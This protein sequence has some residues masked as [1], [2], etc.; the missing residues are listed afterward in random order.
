[1]ESASKYKEDEVKLI[2]LPTSILKWRPVKFKKVLNW[3][4]LKEISDFVFYWLP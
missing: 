2:L 3:N 1:L 4:L